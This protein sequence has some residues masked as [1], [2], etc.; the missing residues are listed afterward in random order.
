MKVSICIASHNMKHLLFD[1]IHSCLSQN[2]SN[3]EIILLDDASTDG[4]TGHA[5]VGDS[6]VKYFRTSKPSG[7]GE[8]FNHAMRLATG[9]IIVLLCADDLLADVHVIGDIVEV[10]KKD[11][12]LSHVSRYYYQFEGE[13]M[14][15][16]VRAWRNDD[17]IELSNNPSGLAFRASKI[18]D[19]RLT[20]KMFVESANLVACA[21][22]HGSYHIMRWDTVAVRIHASTSR[23]SGY[24]LKQWNSSP[25]EEWVKLGGYSLLKDYVSLIQIKNYFKVS[26]VLK[27]AWNF[28][29]LRPINFFVPSFWFFFIVAVFTPR[30]ILRFVPE[31]YR[32]YVGSKIVK[33]IWRP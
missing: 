13:E 32:K 8:A 4:T 26:A 24:Y 11:R 14:S 29:R 25:I 30:F 19:C 15:K 22:R 7:T 21:I 31:V 9:E 16:P 27:E 23:N 18:K 28:V 17:V 3:I 33:K 2:Y 10:F 1:A 6:R 12:N 20:N 5:F